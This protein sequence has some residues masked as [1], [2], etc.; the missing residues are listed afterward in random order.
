MINSSSS[1]SQKYLDPEILN[2]INDLELK[3]RQIVE[4]YITGLHKSPFHGFSVEFAEHREYVAGDDIRYIDWKV[5]A[6]SDRYYIKQYEEETN[7][8]ANILIDSSASMQYTSHNMTKYE[9]ACY[10]A[11]SLAYIILQQQDSV[12]M[13]IFDDT[14]QT[15]LP[16]STNPGYLKD[17]AYSLATTTPLEKTNMNKVLQN[18]CEQIRKKGIILIISDFFDDIDGI[19]SAL[20][21]FCHKKHKIFL[22][23]ILDPDELYFPLKN[24]T[25]F[26]N[27]EDIQSQLLINP[28][29][30]QKAYLKEV[31]DFI[32]KLK[33][34]AISY[35]MTY[36]TITTD[37]PIDVT[38]RSLFLS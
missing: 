33:K 5:Y 4:G 2:K 10:L 8:I 26:E 15:T 13:F 23:H 12:G 30:L 3:A 24:T 7:L 32:K 21:Q 29:F 38:L 35:S 34:G 31:Q 27:L 1:T 6:K 25:L 19:L 20:Q 36:N 22:L 9:Y 28:R 14:I 18:I 11:T 37:Q 17:I 16:P